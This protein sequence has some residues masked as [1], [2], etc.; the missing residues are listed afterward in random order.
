ME[1]VASSSSSSPT[2]T[3]LCVICGLHSYIYT[4]PRCYWGTMMDDYVFLEDIGRIVETHGATISRGSFMAREPRG[5]GRGS[6]GRGRGRGSAAAA[7]VVGGSKKDTLKMQLGFKNISVDFLPEGMEKRRLNQSRWDARE[8]LVFLTVEFVIHPPSGVS[9]KEEV[10]QFKALTHRNALSTPLYR[11]LVDYLKNSKEGRSGSPSWLPAILPLSSDE[12]SLASSSTAPLFLLPQYPP[13]PRPLRLPQRNS[14]R[15]FANPYYTLDPTQSLL[16]ALHSRAFLEYPT[17]ELVSPND[18]GDVFTLM[19][20]F[21]RAMIP[22]TGKV[23]HFPKGRSEGWNQRKGLPRTVHK[24]WWDYLLGTRATRVYLDMKVT[25]SYPQTRIR[26]PETRM[27]GMATPLGMRTVL[28]LADSIGWI[29][30]PEPLPPHANRLVESEHDGE[31]NWGEGE[32]N[33]E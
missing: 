26:G 20:L 33:S 16:Q 28:N 12:T 24:C 10:K 15:R 14:H 19:S 13:R 11:V 7:A 17:I 9:P 5:R 4:C 27:T 3:T 23:S 29:P 6:R 32:Y 18:A 30:R 2:S 31:Y 22:G 21:H 25:V 8:N 1:I